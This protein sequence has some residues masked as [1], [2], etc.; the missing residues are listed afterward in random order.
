VPISVRLL[1]GPEGVTVHKQGVG[2]VDMTGRGEISFTLHTPRTAGT[3]PACTAPASIGNSLRNVEVQV[4]V[5]GPAAAWVLPVL[6]PK[7]Q[8]LQGH[9]LN[10][11]IDDPNGSHSGAESAIKTSNQDSVETGGR[12]ARRALSMPV[13]CD[14][15]GGRSETASIFPAPMLMITEQL[16]GHVGLRIWDCGLTCVKYLADMES[17]VP[18]WASDLRVL[19]L[20]SGTGVVGL[21]FWAAGADVTLTDQSVVLPLLQKN[22]ADNVGGAA[23]RGAERVSVLEYQWGTDIAALG[24]PYD[25]VVCSDLAYDHRAMTPLLS[26][27]SSLLSASP[28]DESASASAPARPKPKALLAYRCS[29]VLGLETLTGQCLEIHPL[30]LGLEYMVHTLTGTTCTCTAVCRARPPV[31]TEVL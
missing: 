17:S 12:E 27:L 25:L 29:D 14:T 1:S 19:E 21:S 5:L 30:A 6:T 26:S 18:G 15:T 7:I 2:F 11:G 28:A 23:G 4:F 24:P 20:G 3:V 8:L 16:G 22:V 10:S 13:G 31:R 9:E